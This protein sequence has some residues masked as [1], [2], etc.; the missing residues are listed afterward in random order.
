MSH[1]T[2]PVVT[3]LT[4]TSLGPPGQIFVLVC[5][6]V[7]MYEDSLTTDRRCASSPWGLRRAASSLRHKTRRQRGVMALFVVMVLCSSGCTS[8]REYVA[9]GF[10]VGPNYCPPHAPV[11]SHWIDADDPNV[12]SA[13]PNPDAWWN[14]FQ[15]STLNG[16]IARAR[17]ENLSIRAACW[18]IM[19]ARAQ[20]AIAAGSLLPQQQQL[21]GG[22]ARKA[23][24]QTTKNQVHEFPFFDQWD[25]GQ[26]L[27]WEL[28]F[29]GRFRRAVEAADAMLDASVDNYH[30]VLV[31]LQA[32][33]AF[34]YVKV[35]T[36]DQPHPRGQTKS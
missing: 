27:A 29:W 18:R 10:R 28:D 1:A 19:E 30:N 13:D 35:R 36:F 24:S 26:P 4:N 21:V 9:N 11:E 25:F 5:R 33:V 8:W 32:D 2:L 15:D 12:D 23:V 16:L 14:I 6:T 31:L 20:A 22:Y 3:I 7:V 17:H 34:A